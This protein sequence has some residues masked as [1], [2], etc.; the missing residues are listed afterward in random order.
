MADGRTALGASALPAIGRVGVVGAD[1]P[2]WGAAATAGYGWT[3]SV[4]SVAGSHHRLAGTLAGSAFPLPWLGAALV[5]DGRYDRHPDDEHGSDGSMVGDPRLV[6]RGWTR[7]TRR[8]AIGA[9]L[10]GWFPGSDAPSVEPAATTLD[11]RGLVSWWG[12]GKKTVLG[13]MGG[14]RLD[15]SAQ[16]IEDAER[17]RPGDRIALGVSDFD[18]LLLGLGVSHALGRTEL[19]ANSTLDWL[20]GTDAP[21]VAESPWRIAVGVRHWLTPPVAVEIKGELLLSRRPGL[22]ATDPLVPVEPRFGISAGL[23]YAWRA[24]VT[25]PAQGLSYPPGS[26]R[27]PPPHPPDDATPGAKVPTTLLSGHITDQTGHA[28]R[29]AKVTLVLPDRKLELETSSEGRFV[30]HELPV[31]P[32]DLQVRAPGYVELRR[33]VALGRTQAIVLELEPVLP[34]GQLR[35]LIRAFTG[36]SLSAKILVE[37]G[38]L[39]TKTDAEGRFELD[40]APGSYQVSIVAD[41]YQQQERRIE[42]EQRGVTVINAELEVT[43]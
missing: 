36:A 16:S 4:G 10:V 27:P 2:D 22:S 5:L 13:V 7:V 42:V 11:F 35:G 15:R 34:A 40:L 8:L 28:L 23:R 21:P 14:Y 18:A 26:Y 25:V 1:V 9:E 39:S 12:S 33:Q 38:G 24:E 6:L 17:L 3:E 20:L 37:P 32:G 41:G 19:L 30:F 29:N 31:G 43:R